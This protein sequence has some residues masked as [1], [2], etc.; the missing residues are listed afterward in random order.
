MEKLKSAWNDT[1]DNIRNNITELEITDK[2]DDTGGN[3]KAIGRFDATETG[4]KITIYGSTDPNDI[5]NI[6]NVLHHEVGHSVD[7]FNSGVTQKFT[8]AVDENPH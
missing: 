3:V 5:D 8:D 7:Y 2:F 6:D 1:P 4:G